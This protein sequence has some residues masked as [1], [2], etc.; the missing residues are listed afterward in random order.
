MRNWECRVEID[1][2]ICDLK[3]KKER[4]RRAEGRR[5]AVR[6]HFKLKP[7]AEKFDYVCF[8][9]EF[10][11]GQGGQDMLIRHDGNF[12]TLLHR[13]SQVYTGGGHV[14]SF[15]FTDDPKSTSCYYWAQRA[16]QGR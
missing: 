9:E 13:L 4:Y 15:H 16:R 10:G 7:T 1:K 6:G 2:A 11:R 5:L 12:K 3:R 14:K 8:R